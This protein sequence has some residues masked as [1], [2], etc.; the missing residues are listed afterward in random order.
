MSTPDEKAPLAAYFLAAF[1]GVFCLL[2]T[3]LL[4]I[5]LS[6]VLRA[7]SRDFMFAAAPAS[8]ACYGL[9]GAAFGFIWPE[10]GWRWGVWL[11]ALPACLVSFFAGRVDAFLLFVALTLAP[12]CAG[13]YVSSRVHL[14]YTRVI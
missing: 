12:A 5:F 7:G 1:A 14:R 11:G 4:A 9:S 10:R 6:D 2:P 8:A 13:A 3:L